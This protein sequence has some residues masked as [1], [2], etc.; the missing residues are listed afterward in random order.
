MLWQLAAVIISLH[1]K[2]TSCITQRQSVAAVCCL[3]VTDRS[4]LQSV[5]AISCTAV[6][7]TQF[8]LIRQQSFVTHR[9]SFR[10]DRKKRDRALTDEPTSM[11]L[12]YRNIG[13]SKDC[14]DHDIWTE[15]VCVCVCVWGW[16]V[17]HT[18]VSWAITFTEIVAILGVRYV[19]T[20]S[21]DTTIFD[22]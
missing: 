17:R 11:L 2:L 1:L 18:A 4:V 22:I 21:R 13:R 12:L 5:A 6:S 16:G 9:Y 20:Y 15:G 10:A 7:L 14:C 3:N 19:N 8:T